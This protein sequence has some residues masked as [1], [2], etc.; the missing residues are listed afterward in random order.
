MTL[1]S[2][3]ALLLLL[4]FPVQ[5]GDSAVLTAKVISLKG[6]ARYDTNR[7]NWYSLRLGDELTPAFVIHTATEGSMVD[8]RLG[9]D[10]PTS[11]GTVRI[12]SNSWVTVVKLATRGVGSAEVKEAEFDLAAGQIL[13]NLNSSSENEVRLIGGKTPVRLISHRRAAGRE[14]TVCLFKL[15]GDLVVLQGSA[16]VSTAVAKSQPVNAGEQLRGDSREVT[17]LPLDAP[18]RKLWP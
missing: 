16:T 12:F 18:E 9:G 1:Y 15:S 14:G 3:V 5:A 17:K 4:S 11:S 8:I 10:G 7:F 2:N 6:S 13:V